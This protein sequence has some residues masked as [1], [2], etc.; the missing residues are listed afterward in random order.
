MYFRNFKE[1]I[2]KIVIKKKFMLKNKERCDDY[3]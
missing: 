1:V 2:V 3:G